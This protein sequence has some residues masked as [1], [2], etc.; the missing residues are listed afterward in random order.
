MEDVEITA[1]VSMADSGGSSGRLRNKIGI[2]P[3]GDALKCVIALSPH[4]EAA[5]TILLKKLH[6]DRRLEGHNAGNMLLAM[7]SGFAGS[8]PSAINALSE[9][10]D[11]RGTVLPGT[12]EKATLVAELS[13]G[14]R[15]YGESAIDVPGSR[16][17]GQIQNLFLVPHH[18]TSISAYPPVIDAIN[19]SDYIFIGPGDLFTSILACL[20]IPGI[21][22][23]LRQT[24][25]KIFY[26]LNIMTKFGETHN[27]TPRDFVGKLE[28][29]ME[30]QV[31]GIVCNTTRPEK[32]LLERYR[33]QRSDFVEINNGKMEAWKG[34]RQVIVGDLLNT[35]ESIVRHDSEKLASLIRN[36]IF[37]LRPV[38]TR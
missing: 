38:D 15:I 25:A 5:K 18:S 33:E 13:N 9:I 4:S 21:M 16:D 23:A 31:A 29:F 10:L 20:V 8:F 7:L 36:I 24:G 22:E 17:R 26:I 28:D 32:E 27:Y 34:D 19:G 3:P 11:A 37:P 1:I 14:K 12:T 35:S 6:G 2:L 30:R